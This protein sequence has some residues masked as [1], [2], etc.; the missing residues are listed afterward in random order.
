ML[1]FQATA[2]PWKSD[3]G[4]EGVKKWQTDTQKSWDGVGWAGSVG[5]HLLILD[6]VVARHVYYVKPWEEGLATVGATSL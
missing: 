1:S 6:V 5:G 3:W 2:W 4:D